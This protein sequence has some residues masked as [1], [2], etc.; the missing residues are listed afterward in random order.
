MRFDQHILGI[1]VVEQSEHLLLQGGQLLVVHFNS[2]KQGLVVLFEG[3]Q[4]VLQV[5]DLAVLVL[6]L[7]LVHFFVQGLHFLVV[8]ERG[9]GEGDLAEQARDHGFALIELES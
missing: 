1:G 3:S 4:R 7:R 5:A 2:G 8:G 9:L 6:D